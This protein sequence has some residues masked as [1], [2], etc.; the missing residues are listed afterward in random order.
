[1]QRLF[2]A[3][4][5]F[6]AA[7]E[8]PF[9]L[10]SPDNL[11]PCLRMAIFFVFLSLRSKPL[12]LFS[13]VRPT[14]ALQHRAR[15]VPGFP[16]HRA[17]PRASGTPGPR[18]NFLCISVASLQTAQTVFLGPTDCCPA[19]PGS[20]RA[21]LPTPPRKNRARGEPRGSPSFP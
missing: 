12:K 1:M 3:I 9:D 19:A 17:T 8:V 7:L 2:Q 6:S 16:P 13:S 18:P 4:F 11:H 14:V 15:P 21:R 5:A 20:A 10:L